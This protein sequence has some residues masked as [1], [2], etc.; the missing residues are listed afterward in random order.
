MIFAPL[1]K[2]DN[3]ALLLADQAAAIFRGWQDATTRMRFREAPYVR[4]VGAEE[5]WYH[6]NVYAPFERDTLF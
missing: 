5:K 3:A 4:Q 6:V 2:G 1:N